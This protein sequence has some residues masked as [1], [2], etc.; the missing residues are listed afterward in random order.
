MHRLDPQVEILGRKIMG[1][2]LQRHGGWRRPA[3]LEI[4][5]VGKGMGKRTGRRHMGDITAQRVLDVGM[6]DLDAGTT[7][8]AAGIFLGQQG[9]TGG[10]LDTGDLKVRHPE[11]ETQGSDARPGPRLENPVACGAGDAGRQ[12]YCIDA[13]PVALFRLQDAKPAIEESI[14][15]QRWGDGRRGGRRNERINRRSFLHRSPVYN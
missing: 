10:K 3:V 14:L 11:G 13:R 7:F 2:R 5:R 12:E 8:I 6:D 9:V 1:A 15:G 4:G